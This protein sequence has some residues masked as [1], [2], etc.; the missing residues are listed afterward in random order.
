MSETAVR[1]V[2]IV[3]EPVAVVNARSCMPIGGL[4]GNW[5]GGRRERRMTP[6]PKSL[7][8]DA[9]DAADRFGI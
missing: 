8:K 4:F 6:A 7:S 9:Q 5:F 3:A 2:R 1:K